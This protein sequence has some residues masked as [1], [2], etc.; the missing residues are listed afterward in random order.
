MPPLSAGILLYRIVTTG[1]EVLIGH[2]GGP[3]WSK[4][5]QGAWSIPKGLVGPGEDPLA[6]ARREFTEETGFDPGHGD[7][8]DL[9]NTVLRSGKLVEAWAILGD[10]DPAAATSNLVRIEWPR[11]S[12]RFIEFPE[13]DE[14]RW[15]SVD[16]AQKLLNPAQQVFLERLI[17]YL[18]HVK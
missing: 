18:D 12:R 7:V 3:F 17:K 10:L 16:E 4:R 11:H 9:G 13:I 6:A 14:L 5:N 1:I 15:C 2:P 8:I